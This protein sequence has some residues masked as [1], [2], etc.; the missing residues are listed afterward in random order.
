MLSEVLA[1]PLP[2]PPPGRLAS[3][4][5]NLCLRPARSEGVALRR[6]SAMVQ[7]FLLLREL[8]TVLPPL[9]AALAPARCE[10]LR[11]LGASAGHV[12]FSA[13]STEL[14]RVWPSSSV[15]LLLVVIVV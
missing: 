12:S 1:H 7:S 11:A 4:C 15:L 9:A 14:D 13:L 2:L 5:V 8:L 3:V 6:I 10:L